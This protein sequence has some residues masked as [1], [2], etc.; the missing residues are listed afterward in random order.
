MRRNED[1]A[2]VQIAHHFAMRDRPDE[3]GAIHFLPGLSENLLGGAALFTIAEEQEMAASVAD[4]SRCFREDRRAVPGTERPG[5]TDDDS[6]L[7]PERTS[8]SAA[9]T[10]RPE[11]KRIDA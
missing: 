6:V 8:N 5:E 10:A 4:S 2:S 1:V 3:R 9:R 11:G 7:Q